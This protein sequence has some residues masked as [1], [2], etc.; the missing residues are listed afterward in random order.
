MAPRVRYFF[1]F[2]FFIFYLFPSVLF[3]QNS[4]L[5]PNILDSFFI[6]PFQLMAL[7]AHTLLSKTGFGRLTF[8]LWVSLLLCTGVV[9][10]LTC[11]I[12]LFFFLHCLCRYHS[13]ALWTTEAQNKRSSSLDGYNQSDW[14]RVNIFCPLLSAAVWQTATLGESVRRSVNWKA[15][16][17]SSCGESVQKE[18]S[19]CLLEWMLGWVF[20]GG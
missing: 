19:L 15:G 1:C 9:N 17:F 2:F 4:T 11:S 13:V 14:L 5:A 10:T 16:A 20:F 3:N 8:W 18:C 6:P 12:Q 7:L